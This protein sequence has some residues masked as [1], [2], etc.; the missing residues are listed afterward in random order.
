MAEFRIKSVGLGNNEAVFN[1]D[2]SKKN[3]I[4]GALGMTWLGGVWLISHKTQ[5]NYI[6]KAQKIG[7]EY[8]EI[9]SAVESHRRN[10]KV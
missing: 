6:K 9:V 7:P 2:G 3:N 4:A 8:V 1:L 10:A 5:R